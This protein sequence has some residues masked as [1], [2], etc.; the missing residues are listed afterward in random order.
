MK[1][2]L[3]RPFRAKLKNKCYTCELWKLTWSLELGELE[4]LI[5]ADLE[6]LVRA[7]FELCFRSI[8]EE[9]YYGEGLKPAN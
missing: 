4:A 6:D 2:S 9:S 3:S 1:A 5:S 7:A 8:F